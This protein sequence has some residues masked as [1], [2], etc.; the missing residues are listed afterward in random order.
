[1]NKNFRKLLSFILCFCLVI[2]CVPITTFA[3]AV[4]VL[5]EMPTDSENISEEP[6]II[7][8]IESKRE[9]NVKHFRMS[10]GS[11]MAVSYEM[12]VHFLN[13]NNKFEEYDNSLIEYNTQNGTDFTNKKSD[14]DIFLSQ[15]AK[16]NKMI[17]IN[18][19]NYEIYWGFEKI[20]NSD[21][22]IVEN[23]TNELSYDNAYLN[24]DN[25]VQEVRYNNVYQDVD[26]QYFILPNGI[27]ENIILNN[28]NTQRKFI[29]R[30]DIGK[31]SAI[32]IDSKTIE[33]RDSN[34]KT[35]YEIHA[36]IMIDAD[37][38][39]S[40]DVYL[41]ITKTNGNHISVLITVDENWLDEEDR[42]YPVTIDPL[43]K[44]TQEREKNTDC[45]VSKSS[46][47]TETING[48]V[49]HVYVGKTREGFNRAFF[50]LCM[51][52]LD[53]S[54]LITRALL[55]LYTSGN[56]VPGTGNYKVDAHEITSDW[57]VS[58]ISFSHPYD[59]NVL[60]YCLVSDTD[61]TTYAW[62]ITRTVK[63]WHSTGKNYGIML[64]GSTES[65]N[66]GRRFYNCRQDNSNSE[67]RPCLY[68]Y[69][70]NTKGL[71]DYNSYKSFDYGTYGS[72]YINE[73]T[74]SITYIFNDVNYSGNL[75]NANVY[76]VYNSE[77]YNTSSAYGKGWRLNVCEALCYVHGEN[78]LDD[79]YYYC[80]TDEDGTQIYFLKNGDNNFY[81]DEVGRGWK[82]TDGGNGDWALTIED[83]SGNKKGYNSDGYLKVVRD[84]NGNE[85]TFGYTNSLVT[86]ITDSSG[87]ITTLSYSE[88]RLDYIEDPAGR[89]T[90]YS[91]SSDGYLTNVERYNEENI[92]IAYWNNRLDIVY[93]NN[94]KIGVVYR[95]NKI[96]YYCEGITGQ[97]FT[98]KLWADYYSNGK[99]VFTHLGPS[100]DISASDRIL[101]YCLF[102]SWGQKITNYCT[103]ANGNILGNIS[104]A[105]YIS[106]DNLIKRNNKLT[107]SYATS[108]VV[109][110]LPDSSFENGGSWNTIYWASHT[111]TAA[112]LGTETN[113]GNAY[114]GQDYG[115]ITFDV[116]S[117]RTVSLFQNITGL[118]EGATYTL[119]GYVKAENLAGSS[120][121]FLCASSYYNTGG[122][123]GGVYS[124][125]IL[126]TTDPEVDGGWKRISVTFTVPADIK[127]VQIHAGVR[128]G[129]S[130]SVLFDCI[131]LEKGTEAGDYNL[132]E[133]AGFEQS[134][135]WTEKGIGTNDGIS[136]S[137]IFQGSQS[138]KITGDH[139][140]QKHISQK[141]DVYGSSNDVYILSAWAK[142]TS[143]SLDDSSRHFYIECKIKYT[144]G[145]VK[146]PGIYEFDAYNTEWQYLS[147]VISVEK[148]NSQPKTI[149]V[150]A[151]YYYNQ[152]ICYFDN[153]QLVRDRTQTYKYD[154]DGNLKD[155][156]S[157]ANESSQ[158]E[159][160]DNE[161]VKSIA[162][163]GHKYYN[164]YSNSNK[165]LLISSY[166]DGVSY[167]FEHDSKGNVTETTALS[168]EIV[169]GG[170]YAFRTYYENRAVDIYRSETVDGTRVINYTWNNTVN[171]HFCLSQIDGT[172][173]YS[174]HPL[175]ASDKALT[176]LN[177]GTVS[178]TDVRLYTYTGAYNQQFRF[179]LQPNGS[180]HVIPRHDQNKCW[181]MIDTNGADIEIWTN[182]TETSKDIVVEIIQATEGSL[183]M[184][185][186]AT[187]TTSGQYLSTVT[188]T[189]GN[190]VSYTYDEAKDELLS[191]TDAKGNVTAYENTYGTTNTSITYVDTDKNGTLS[192]K[193]A[194]VRYK[195]SNGL[196]NSIDNNLNYYN[197][198]YDSYGNRTRSSVGTYNLAE[199]VYN[200]VNGNLTSLKYGNGHETR[201]VYDNL[202]RL[203]EVW[204]ESPNIVHVF[205]YKYDIDG[206]I[207]SLYE[208]S[209]DTLTKFGYDS[210]G[211]LVNAVSNNGFSRYQSYD[212]YNR[213]NKITYSRAGTSQTYR[214]NYNE[215]NYIGSV[216]LPTG[217]II[218]NSYDGLNRLTVK[219]VNTANPIT[220]SYTYKAG[221][222]GTASNL[223]SSVTTM[224]GMYEYTY[225]ANG[226]I[227]SISKNGELLESY[228]YDN[229]NQLKTVTKGTDVY[230]YNYDISGNIVSVLLNGTQTDS[231]GYSDVNWRDKLTSFNGQTIT[232]DGIGNPL[233]YRDGISF[234]WKYGRTLE[235]FDNLSYN[236][237]YRYN[238][239]GIRVEK[240]ITDK[241]TGATEAH[242][243]DYN[244][245]MLI[246]ERW[247]NNTVWYLYDESGSPVGFTYNGTEYYYLKNMQGDITGIANANGTVV[248][249]YS[250][251]VWG[252]VLSVTGSMAD[253]IGQINS[254]RYR[255]YYY[256]IETGFYLTGTRYYDPEIGRFINADGVIS[257]T[258]ESVQGY[259]LFAYCFNNPVN[260][261]DPSGN[262]P[263]WATKLVA[264]VAV[265][266]VVAAV[267]AVTV[268]TAGAGTA[269]AAVA[270]GAAKG[271]AIGFAVGAASGAAI[272]YATT[273]TLEG[274]LNGMADGALS[275]SI[276]GAITGG[277]QGYSNYSNYTSA[278]NFLKNNG[279]NPDEVM[280]CFKGTPKVKTLKTDTTVY[281][282]WG[283]TTQELGHWVSPNNYGSSARNL[284]SL[285][286]GNTMAHTSSFLLPKG[287][288]VLAG[289]AAPLFG[290]SG[291]G[292]QWWIS[293]LG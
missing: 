233:T 98:I 256:D 51:P 219:T 60:D 204:K 181:D 26:L 18:A 208:G 239:D 94:S 223:V 292:V 197:F 290:Q 112:Y 135:S 199:Y 28:S 71:N 230:E 30:Y 232:Y 42:I 226:N 25:I 218:S 178:G 44:E 265:V 280:S 80:Y 117:E 217:K 85:M 38:N 191:T 182:N 279:Q 39:E 281:R 246:C 4:D 47:G 155:V 154:D 95:G 126:G 5:T 72:L 153:I 286:A 92:I 248:V 169:D 122:H 209:T 144:D 124:E 34:N 111:D 227:T 129:T 267:A 70:I 206:N 240:H 212:A 55:C 200:Q 245:T 192:N 142:A 146:W 66:V 244:G 138:Y 203:C 13:E 87:R 40:D 235:Y 81:E 288:T 273:G 31:L 88:G 141:I 119:S 68:V 97:E 185:S 282:T 261:S 275:G 152:N 6:F 225:D 186:T 9:V 106:N 253:T 189:L 53:S 170:V 151:G 254:L 238:A 110:L 113:S 59:S 293:V 52:E 17:R 168:S 1:M 224:Q 236:V 196:L 258:G 63:K 270:V 105:D 176:V 104:S 14:K 69:Y 16:Q 49:R 73:Y 174:I 67:V 283:G 116:P 64:K 228:T 108:N 166:A 93:M 173:Y 193:E 133:N 278:R 165:H 213:I 149:T 84:S 188:D 177:A 131:Q 24:L 274:T 252:K 103:D 195:T 43:I 147:R 76:H 57:S 86:S 214:F 247:D 56:D 33:L 205:R 21:I 121:A 175:I 115:R 128:P 79:K 120:G 260:M 23:K 221:I 272:G 100:G 101:E 190:T 140:Q 139:A 35:I 234:I 184:Q 50:K 222:N 285:P 82:L 242:Y 269:I 107:E 268:A 201:Y 78:N 102:N 162:K 220:S 148:G 262:W 2:S 143:V 198:G 127:H 287:T 183:Q 48:D 266:A 150:Y 22:E 8:E 276:S 257:G 211:R 37:G 12:P 77:S 118:T 187:Y 45:Y 83:K 250:Y 125:H 264:A 132:V 161:V 180:Y 255:G 29:Q 136:N 130:G 36:P 134:G 202:N 10:D 109:N 231:Y 207:S 65:G 179:E 41:S 171:Q 96:K 163:T 27:K 241:S 61:T 229:L 54:D 291:G 123:N 15:K 137:Q 194:Y 156:I 216:S 160:S 243:Y 62:D 91:Y 19:N 167:Q 114:I 172:E 99:T 32:Q 251:D 11:Y 159:Y 277:V 157:I 210:I 89:R 284:L 90:I 271:A 259:N 158:F 249:E 46:S 237:F 58:N 20:N 75:L 289:K 74:G 263:K 215:K 3:T 164:T 145:T 7:E